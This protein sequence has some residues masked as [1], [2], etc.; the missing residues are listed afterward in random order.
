L[1]VKIDQWDQ[2]MPE[3]WLAGPEAAARLGVKPQTLYAYVSR[4]RVA[5]K[6]DPD[7]PRKSLYRSDDLARLVTRKARGRRAADV[8]QGA[9]SWG[10]PVLASAI[11]EVADGRLY[12]RG[13]DAAR[14][15]EQE[16]L[17]QVATRL[18]AC[19]DEDV[20]VREARPRVRM[21]GAPEA[22]A[23]AALAARAGS[24][25]PALGRSPHALWREGASLMADLA[26]ALGEGTSEGPL[27]LILAEAWGLAPSEADPVRRALVLLADHELNASTFACRVAASTG[28][29]LAACALAGLAALSG[30]H[31]GGA[32]ARVF[33]MIDDAQREGPEGALR[34]WTARG[35][36]PAGFAHPL[37]PD[38]DPRAKALFEA[39]RPSPELLALKT[40]S[41]A[42]CGQP[43]NVDFAL[44]AMTLALGLPR[45]APFCLFALG[46]SAGWIAHA[47]EQVGS[48]GL[49]RPRAR[50]VGPPPEV[51]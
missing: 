13:A 25:A 41:E 29:S 31:H 35:A 12:Y 45:H 38:G 9:I 15:A 44:A 43:A 47:L 48:G 4:G 40:A 7:D 49:I 37:Y 46:R 14:L 24:D 8:A 33:A 22:K 10:E 20:F 5:A 2:H 3:S 32:A 11:T 16:P 50:Y 39:F 36:R 17:E 26:G 6:P 18:W 27:H 21:R 34:A 28:A 23:F 1:T 30:P 42:H 51:L 19:G